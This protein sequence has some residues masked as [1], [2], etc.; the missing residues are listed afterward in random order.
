[1]SGISALNN[2]VLGI[3]KG[4]EGA[5]RNA[6]DIASADQFNQKDTASL[7]TS[8]VELKQNTLLVKA[9]GKAFEMISDAIGSIINI[10][11]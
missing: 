4:L 2:A 5:K 8:L 11:V 6:A 3:Q 7:V 9:S 10:K 1:M